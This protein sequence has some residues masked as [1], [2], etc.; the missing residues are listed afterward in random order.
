MGR[1]VEGPWF[2]A[3]KNGWYATVGGKKVALG[4]K[5]QERRA[6]AVQAW[7]R[8]MAGVP[9]APATLPPL[10]VPQPEPPPAGFT[11]RELAALV[12]ADAAS[13]LK[14]HTIQQYRADLVH[15]LIRFGDSPADRVAPADVARWL[16]S[17]K[18][19]DTTKSIRLR[20]VSA[21][22]G[23]AVRCELIG[24]NPLK[25]VPKPRSRSRGKEAVISPENRAKLMA[26]ASPA[27]RQVLTVLHGTGC[28]PGEAC[29]ITAADF[30]P[31]NAVARLEEHKSDHHGQPR[32][33]FLPPDVVALFT[34]L[35]VQH[36]AGPL[37][38]TKYGNPWT[39]RSVT[40]YMQKLKKRAGVKAMAYGFRHGFATDALV[41]GLPD[42]Q[43]A[44]LLGHSS[45]TML[46][47]HYSHLTGQSRVL[48]D[49]L[50]KVRGETPT[51]E[52]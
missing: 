26:H 40:E 41:K 31:D 13:R 12:L 30:D 6:E 37:L 27:F 29:R 52:K 28:R 23:W 14:P 19:S 36:P 15:F 42:A 18:V 25:R 17:F 4:V 20:S 21:A 51:S 16:H 10:A 32:L 44:A 34:E 43:V 33:I 11:V 8:L 35:A 50:A 2:R 5:G 45:T 1:H 48:R 46:H 49:A 39:G 9:T 24:D 7:H 38:R 22:F 3:S 47:K